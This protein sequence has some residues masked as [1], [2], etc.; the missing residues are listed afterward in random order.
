MQGGIVLAENKRKVGHP[1]A[2][3]PKRSPVTI[4]LT[5]DDYSRLKEYSER[6]SKTMTQVIME[7]IEL[8]YAKG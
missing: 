6:H 5:A 8:V 3:N 1:F 7:G 4:R 2:D